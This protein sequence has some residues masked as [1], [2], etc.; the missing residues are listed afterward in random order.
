MPDFHQING[1]KNSG[2]G[3]AKLWFDPQGHKDQKR[4]RKDHIFS[5][6][7]ITGGVNK[8]L[9]VRIWKYIWIIFDFMT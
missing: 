6:P 3:F 2:N 7:N 8:F 4:S 5:S 9:Q 1:V